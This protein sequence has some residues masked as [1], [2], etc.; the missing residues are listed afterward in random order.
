MGIIGNG[1]KLAVTAPIGFIADKILTDSAIKEISR[2]Q[3]ETMTVIDANEQDTL[4]QGTKIQ[5]FMIFEGPNGIKKSVKVEVRRFF[6]FENDLEN[7]GSFVCKDYIFKGK[8][9]AKQ[10]DGT[11]KNSDIYMYYPEV[12]D[13]E[14]GN[15]IGPIVNEDGTVEQG[16]EYQYIENGVMYTSYY[17]L[18]EVTSGI[19]DF[20]IDVSNPNKSGYSYGGN[21]IVEM[22][23]DHQ[24]RLKMM[25]DDPA[26][27]RAFTTFWDQMRNDTLKNDEWWSREFIGVASETQRYILSRTNTVTPEELNRL[28]AQSRTQSEST[29]SEKAKLGN[30]IDLEFMKKYNYATYDR[31]FHGNIAAHDSW[32]DNVPGIG[33]PAPRGGMGMG[34]GPMPGGGPRRR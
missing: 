32:I 18:C 7:P 23:R 8:V 25:A 6:G 9:K 22:E 31:I 17:P 26:T 12:I 14:T 10:V 2:Y 16:K 15:L 4:K 3:G 13:M 21:L 11:W 29:K 34:Y 19:P 33:N 27:L 1:I 28:L 30:G 5:T 20:D 24:G